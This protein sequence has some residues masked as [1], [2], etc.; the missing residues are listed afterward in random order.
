MKNFAK[1]VW[2]L[3]QHICFLLLY[4]I[5]P[6]YDKG[7]YYLHYMKH[8]KA[9]SLGQ[10]IVLTKYTTLTEYKHTLGH[11]KQSLYLGPLYLLLI[12]VPSIISKLL[13]LDYSKQPW[14]LWADRLGGLKCF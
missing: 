13:R 10:Y 5:L 12:G 2:Q 1:Y 4:A 11:A 7:D 3:P 9:F 6:I 14:E 8:V